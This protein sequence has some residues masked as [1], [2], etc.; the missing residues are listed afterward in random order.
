MLDEEEHSALQARNEA[1]SGSILSVKSLAGGHALDIAMLCR[2]SDGHVV[3]VGLDRLIRVWNIRN[4]RSYVVVDGRQG[5]RDIFPV[6]AIE[7]DDLCDWLVI[8][9]TSRV[10]FWSLRKRQWAEAVEIESQ[11]RRVET[12]FLSSRRTSESPVLIIVWR[13]GTVTDT[14]RGP[15]GQTIEF[16]ISPTPLVSAHCYHD[17]C[18]WK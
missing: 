1:E 14:T 5:K 3:S 7:I 8:V 2:S 17:N 9:S 12:T 4:N 10:S 16:T 11:C 6:L 15:R 13:D 18:E